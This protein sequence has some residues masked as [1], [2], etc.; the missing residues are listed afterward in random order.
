MSISQFT[1]ESNDDYDCPLS[2]EEQAEQMLRQCNTDEY[3]RHERYEYHE[4][5]KGYEPYEKRK[6]HETFLEGSSISINARNASSHDSNTSN[7]S[8]HDNVSKHHMLAIF[9]FARQCKTDYESQPTN[10]QLAD[11]WKNDKKLR[12]VEF[13]EFIP[14]FRK[15]WEKVKHKIGEGPLADAIRKAKNLP[16]PESLRIF[17][18]CPLTLIARLCQV[19][20]RSKSG[21]FPLSS[22]ALA[23]ELGRSQPSVSRAL[24]YLVDEKFITVAS[25]GSFGVANKYNYVSYASF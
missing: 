17:G 22:V 24:R 7:A 18:D 14:L 11:L 15:S 5:H 12:E 4:R 9:R 3:E 21:P 19:L 2:I 25:R 6:T 8:S 20:G 13:C 16:I 23:Q 1:P 10:D